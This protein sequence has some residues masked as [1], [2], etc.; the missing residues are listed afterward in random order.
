MQILKVAKLLAYLE[1][2]SSPV[3]S[4][5]SDAVEMLRLTHGPSG[6]GSG[7]VTAEAE[8]LLDQ[9]RDE[10]RAKESFQGLSIEDRG[11]GLSAL[12]DWSDFLAFYILL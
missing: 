8:E 3:M 10:I 1:P 11:D 12:C 4:L 6:E 5:F 9:L 2:V 7:R